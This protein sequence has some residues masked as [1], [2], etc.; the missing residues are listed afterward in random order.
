[1]KLGGVVASTDIG[2]AATSDGDLVVHAL[3]DALLGAAALGDLGS[4]FPSSD[5]QWLG[6]DSFSLLAKAVSAAAGAG[7]QAQFVDVT[8]V[9]QSIRIAPIR[10]AIRENLA[11]ALGLGLESV[12]VK[13]T[14]TDT[15]GWIGRDEGLAV[16]ASVTA[17]RT[18]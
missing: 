3:I 13:A 4:F 6:V 14:T 10:S 17:A 11:R 7:W 8:I 15:M 5:P 12:S 9:S 2:V 18:P 1:M 16:A